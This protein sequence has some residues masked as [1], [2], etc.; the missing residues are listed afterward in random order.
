[1]ELGDILSLLEEVLGAPTGGTRA[2]PQILLLHDTPGRLTSCDFIAV[3]VKQDD[4]LH[5][6][7]SRFS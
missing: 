1:M 2:A 3:P 5:T 6:A 4:T 7:L